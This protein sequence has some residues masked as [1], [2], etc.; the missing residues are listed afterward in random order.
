M[1]IIASIK[2]GEEVRYISHLD[3]QRS[4]QRTVRRANIPVAFSQ[5]FNPHPQIS[6][7]TALS[8]CQTGSGEWI[9][10]KLD[11]DISPDE[12]KARMN[13]NFPKGMSIEEAF[14]APEGSPSVANLMK[15]ADYTATA[16]DINVTAFLAAVKDIIDSHAPILVQKTKKQ[17]GR[18]VETEADLRPMLY[19]FEVVSHTDTEVTVKFSGRLDTKGGLNAELLLKCLCKEQDGVVWKINRDRVVI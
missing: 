11:E 7:A 16:S 15:S 17:S 12:F 19:S 6:F 3:I 2:K 8:V 10:I 1:K 5:G 13:R 9:E 4:L 14:V 18:K